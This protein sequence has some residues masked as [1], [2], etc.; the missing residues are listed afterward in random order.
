VSGEWSG[1]GNL[2]G[3]NIGDILI[4]ALQAE[5]NVIANAHSYTSQANGECD[6]YWTTEFSGR[7]CMKYKCRQVKGLSLPEKLTVYAHDENNNGAEI[8]HISVNVEDW[9]GGNGH[10]QCGWRYSQ[11]AQNAISAIFGPWT[12]AVNAFIGIECDIV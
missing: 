7:L 12:L 8:G 11:Y 6:Q 1:N 4:S 3:W 10:Q 2:N 9:S 5:L